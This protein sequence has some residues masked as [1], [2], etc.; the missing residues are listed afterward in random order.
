[1]FVDS[2]FHHCIIFSLMDVCEIFWTEDAAGLA[3][4]WV[5]RRKTLKTIFHTVTFL[6]RKSLTPAHRETTPLHA[7]LHSSTKGT[8]RSPC[9]LLPVMSSPHVA[10]RWRENA[11]RDVFSTTTYCDLDIQEA[12]L[13]EKGILCIL[14]QYFFLIYH[15]NCMFTVHQLVI[16]LHALHIYLSFCEVLSLGAHYPSYSRGVLM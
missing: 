11:S 4:W 15:K 6:W 8:V 5:R 16:S 1:M 2:L 3:E 9:I 12:Y 13:E 7:A 14:C 10:R